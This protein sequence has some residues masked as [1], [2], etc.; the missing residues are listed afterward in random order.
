M[1][2][3]YFCLI[4]IMCLWSK[5]Q[6]FTF[7]LTQT[8]KHGSVMETALCN[9][10]TVIDFNFSP[11]SIISNCGLTGCDIVTYSIYLVRP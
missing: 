5:V 9:K 7:D 3:K 4:V 8:D 10:D 11:D 1:Y 2:L 6:C